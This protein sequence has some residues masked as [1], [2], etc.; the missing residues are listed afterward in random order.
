MSRKYCQVKNKRGRRAQEA[1]PTAEKLVAADG[2]WKGGESVFFTDA[3]PGG[4]SLFPWMVLY[5]CAM[6][7][8]CP[9]CSLGWLQAETTPL[10]D[11]LANPS[12]VL[13]I[14]HVQHSR[15]PPLKKVHSILPQF[16]CMCVCPFSIP[17]LP[18]S[19]FQDQAR[20]DTAP[21]LRQT[22]T[23]A[24]LDQISPR[25]AKLPGENTAGDSLE[26][27]CPFC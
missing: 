26:G 21:S 24:H 22:L 15:C 14:T 16:F 25:H 3:A 12:L 13:Y 6:V 27:R 19:G 18:Q 11:L 2:W 9:V 17:L 4:L 7:L 5:P 10:G 23:L 8:L 1:P 20:Q